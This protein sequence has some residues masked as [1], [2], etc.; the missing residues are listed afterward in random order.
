MVLSRK[1]YENAF[2][3]IGLLILLSFVFQFRFFV[4]LALLFVFFVLLFPLGARWVLN[5]FDR[6]T[7][8]VGFVVSGV[9]LSAIFFFVLTP[10]GML[11]QKVNKDPLRL[12]RSKVPLFIEKRKTYLEK[13]YYHKQW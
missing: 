7:K 1:N 3:V 8:V 4:H 9:L 5:Y 10:L 13:D 6:A 2:V 12:K 11:Y